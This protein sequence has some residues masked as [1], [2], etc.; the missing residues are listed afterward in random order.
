[1]KLVVYGPNRR[2][3]VVHDDLVI[4]VNG[5]GA[6]YLAEVVGDQQAVETAA[7]V[8]PDEL[9]AFIEA[10]ERGIET[11]QRAVEHLT[12]DAST[13]LGLRSE[14]LAYPLS[15]VKLNAPYPRR[16]RIM[17]AGGNYVIHSAGM[18][19]SGDGPAPTLQELYEQSRKRGIWGFY[20]FPENA[21]GPDEDIVYPSRTDRLDYEGEVAVILGMKGKD[22]AADKAAPYFWGYLLQNDISAPHD[23]ACAGPPAVELP[24]I[25]E[26]RR[27]DC[28]GAVRRG[29]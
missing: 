8:T 20:C 6:K 27:F 12:R 29:G 19:R 24:A 22:I 10:G 16:T 1:M 5:V 7:A 18:T 21:A 4:D 15:G 9:G 28:R 2:L 25:E 17:M 14:L 26:L 11:V 3:G 13:Q 23:A